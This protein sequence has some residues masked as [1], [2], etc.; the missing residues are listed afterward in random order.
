MSIEPLRRDL[1]TPRRPP[2]RAPVTAVP[3]AAQPGHQLCLVVPEVADGDAVPLVQTLQR[4]GAH[5]VLVLARQA[6]R[7][8]LSVLLSAGIR[9]AVVGTTS[10][11]LTRATT[12]PTSLRAAAELT[13]RE[14]GVLE[15]VA[16]GRSNKRIG[17]DLGLSALTVKSHLARISR[18]LGT[19]DRAELV[20]IAFR[21]G[22]LR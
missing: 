22:V 3:R 2:L 18:K 9:G 15:L 14:V 21:A 12:A 4:R 19:G 6:A 13:S 16:E 20:A 17:E 5:R 1:V 10:S 11:T 7:R 8:E